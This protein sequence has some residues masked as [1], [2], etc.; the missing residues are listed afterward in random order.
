MIRLFQ[1]SLVMFASISSFA[2]GNMGG[3]GW[4]VSTVNFSPTP[5]DHSQ[6]VYFINEEQ[7]LIHFKTGKFDPKTLEWELTNRILQ[8][9]KLS[10]SV[11]EALQVSFETQN[12]SQ[13]TR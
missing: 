3:G 5:I 6:V 11:L 7:G 13:V 12:W 10:P 9:D 2:S 4:K 1:F 8:E